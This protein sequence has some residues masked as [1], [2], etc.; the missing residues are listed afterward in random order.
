MSFRQCGLGAHMNLL[1]PAAFLAV[2]AA[3]AVHVAAQTDAPLRLSDAI[4]GS[5]VVYTVK[6]GDSLSSIGARMGVDVSMLWEQNGRDLRAALQPGQTL[7]VDNR[8]VVP[9]GVSDALVVNIPQRMLFLFGPG[10]E[11]RGYPVAVGR[12]TW[13]TPTGSFSVLSKRLKSTWHVPPSIQEEICQNGREPLTSV[14]PGPSNPLGDRWLVL[15]L[16]SVGI[17]GTSAP[18]SI[19]TFQT[20]G[21]IRLHPDDM[22]DVFERVALQDAGEV[23]YEPVLI[24]QVGDRVFLEVRC[25]REARRSDADNSP[26]CG[27]VPHSRTGLGQSTARRRVA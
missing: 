3:G 27:A 22:R 20:D 25:V 14:L 4:V 15:S 11:L 13:Q 2:A 19:Y 23:I 17:H 12:P 26:D 8:H 5:V 6:P 16:P 24:A 7:T 21:C 18:Q 1:R 9:G 10:D